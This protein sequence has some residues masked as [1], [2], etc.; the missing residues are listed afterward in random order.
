MSVNELKMSPPTVTIRPCYYRDLESIETMLGQS[1]P[2]E[3]KPFQEQLDRLKSNY[4]LYKFL[5][6][7]PNPC[8]YDS[9]L[10]VAEEKQELKGIIHVHPSN[11]SRSTW[12]VSQVITPELGMGLKDIGSQ[13]LKYCF[14]SIWEA[15]TWVLEVGINDNQHLGLY[16]QNGFQPLAELTHWSVH[17]EIVQALAQ[18]T[19]DLPNLLSVSNADASLLYQLDTVSMPPLLRQVFDRH[20]ADFKTGFFQG[21]VE[22]FRH[23][24]NHTEIVEGYVFEPQRKAAIGYFKLTL[25]QKGEQPHQADLTVHPA[26]TWLYPKLLTQMAKIVQNYPLQALHLTSADYQPEREQYLTQLGGEPIQRT[27]L[28]SRSVWH[29]LREAKPREALHLSEVL[30]GFQPSRPPIPSRMSWLNTW[31]PFPTKPSPSKDNDINNS[32]DLDQ[33]HPLS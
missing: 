9:C 1:E 18:Q 25:S 6:W 12:K 30:Q 11:Q 26:Y 17:P 3:F 14:E 28:M 27:L 24:W 32:S 16:R 31:T 2:S 7:F 10:Y 23:W 15:R 8:Q 29:K 13:L 4:G 33:D 5:S 20:I 22:K 19:P 21:T